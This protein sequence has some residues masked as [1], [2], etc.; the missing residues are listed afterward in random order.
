M[1]IG[2][3]LA[4]CE[5][6]LH[7]AALDAELLRGAWEVGRLV[8][9]PA[10]RSHPEILKTCFFLTLMRFIEATPDA[11]FFA[12]CNALLSRLYRRFGFSMLL[13]D[14]VDIAGEPFSVIHG[15]VPT[16]TQAVAASR[17]QP[18]QSVPAAPVPAVP[19]RAPVHQPSF[20]SGPQPSHPRGMELAFA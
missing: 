20:L 8:L 12:S 6:I 19:V 18:V 17:A 13:K 7:G 14:A 5:K 15:T 9:A 10:Y 2:F 1:P 16:V 4:P 11:N 3:G